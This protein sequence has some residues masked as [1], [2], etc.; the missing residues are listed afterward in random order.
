MRVWRVR[1]LRSSRLRR[2]PNLGESS[3]ST[4]PQHHNTTTPQHHNTTTPQ[5]HNTTTPQHHNTTTPQH[6][7]TTPRLH[8]STTPQYHTTT[9]PRHATPRHHPSRPLSPRPR[10]IQ[11]RHATRRRC[12]RNLRPHRATRLTSPRQLVLL[13]RELR[14]HLIHVAIVLRSLVPEHL[15]RGVSS[16]FLGCLGRCEVSAVSATVMF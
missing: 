10:S 2:R 5:H 7:N 9:P 15:E 6:H 14:V 3:V 8:E 11:S 12:G 4:I 1:G 13:L 16:G